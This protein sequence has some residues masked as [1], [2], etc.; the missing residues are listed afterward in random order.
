[1]RNAI[2]IEHWELEIQRTRVLL[3]APSLTYSG[4]LGKNYFSAPST[5]ISFLKIE[6]NLVH[7]KMIL[8]LANIGTLNI[9]EHL[10]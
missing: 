10:I 8:D 9:L 7:W 2:S 3:P 1:M 4:P 6:I 5:R